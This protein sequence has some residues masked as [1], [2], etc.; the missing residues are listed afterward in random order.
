MKI[1]LPLSLKS[2]LWGMHSSISS[3]AIIP[4]TNDRLLAA[5]EGSKFYPTGLRH[6][7]WAMQPSNS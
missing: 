5:S 6:S 4:K 2:T 7:P 3:L 1:L